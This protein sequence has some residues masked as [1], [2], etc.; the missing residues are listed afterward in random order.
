MQDFPVLLDDPGARLVFN[1]A[2]PDYLAIAPVLDDNRSGQIKIDQ[3][4]K[5]VPFMAHKPARGRFR[6]TVIDSMDEVNR[7]GAN[8]MLKLL[9]EPPENSVIFLI[10]SRPGQL[11]TTIRSRCRLFRL[12]PLD[13][14]SCRD[15]LTKK[16]SD[17]DS[18]QID[19]LSQL[20]ALAHR[21]KPFRS[22]RA[23][24][25]IV[26]KSPVLCWLSPR[27]I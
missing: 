15:V 5:M 4:R 26:I 27:L 21:D 3:I 7:N 17:A 8:A 18:K 12:S 6:V 25:L 9:E 10:S 11:P 14:L 13:A 16:L 1:G 23:G 24:L 22:P 2:H 20:C 19:L